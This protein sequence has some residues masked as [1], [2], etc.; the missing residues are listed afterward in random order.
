ME[1][2]LK[3]DLNRDWLL[4]MLIGALLV[5]G[6]LRYRFP[7]RMAELM[8]LPINDKYFALEGRQKGI[9]HPFNLAMLGVQITAFGLLLA[10]LKMTRSATPELLNFALFIKGI[11]VISLY[12]ILRY[13]LDWVVGYIFNCQKILSEY[14][15]QRLSFHHLIAL[16]LL[17]LLTIMFFSALSFQT[18]TPVILFGVIFALFTTVIYSVRRNSATLI[19]NFLYFILYI[20]ALEIAPYALLYQAAMA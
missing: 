11:L 9:G 6:L 14:R 4:L 20:C 19:T 5:L 15:Y 10:A 17:F 13:S 1:H 2:L 18:L 7:R 8:L 3:A 16:A 12:L